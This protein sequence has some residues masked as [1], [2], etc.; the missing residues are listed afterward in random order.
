MEIL[1]C[2]AAHP[3]GLRGVERYRGREHG[4]ELAAIAGRGAVPTGRIVTDFRD[5]A[6][7]C[8]GVICMSRD[9]VD[10]RTNRRNI[11][12]YRIGAS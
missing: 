10:Q 4:A 7:G 5:V 11:T 2:R 12:E 8:V 9:C 1:T 3:A 6:A